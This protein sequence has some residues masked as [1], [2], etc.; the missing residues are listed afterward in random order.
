[1]KNELYLPEPALSRAI[2]FKKV[3]NGTRVTKEYLEENG[4]MLV[5]WYDED[6]PTDEHEINIDDNLIRGMNRIALSLYEDLVQDSPEAK[7]TAEGII[8]ELK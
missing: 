6:A 2:M 7:I 8:F 1:M 3:L 5:D 4:E